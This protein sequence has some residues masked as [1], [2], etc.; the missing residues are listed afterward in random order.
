VTRFLSVILLAL[1]PSLA[2]G[3]VIYDS[4]SYPTGEQAPTPPTA[5]RPPEDTR[6]TTAQKLGERINTSTAEVLNLSTELLKPVVLAKASDRLVEVRRVEVLRRSFKMASVTIHGLDEMCIQLDR[7]LRHAT[8]AYDAAAKSYRD[9]AEDYT[10]GK[11]KEAC[12]SWAIHYEKLRDRCP[13]HRKQLSALRKEIPATVLLI[14]ESGQLMDDYH[15]FVSTFETEVVPDSLAQTHL[16]AIKDYARKFEAFEK[17]LANYR[18]GT[19]PTGGK[20]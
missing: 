10:D 20:K 3:Q 6:N 7:E 12:T 8:T 18:N 19:N 15:L 1:A 9:R 16:D 14:R 4:K 11:L 17:A 13:E 2:F 5:V